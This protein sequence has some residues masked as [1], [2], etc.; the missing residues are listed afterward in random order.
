MI[1]SISDD[2]VKTVTPRFVGKNVFSYRWK[3]AIED[4]DATAWLFTFYLRVVFLA[5]TAPPER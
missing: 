5:I 3:S 1:S 4:P 2:L